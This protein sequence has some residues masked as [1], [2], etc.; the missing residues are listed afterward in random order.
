MENQNI[1]LIKDTEIM[2]DEPV[3]LTD[4]YAHLKT[5]EK[6][7]QYNQVFYEKNKDKDIKRTCELC[8]GKYTIFNHSHHKKSKKHIKSLPI[9]LEDV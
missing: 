3:I 7:R 8:G 9:K 5:A 6:R 1:E 2:K 4:K